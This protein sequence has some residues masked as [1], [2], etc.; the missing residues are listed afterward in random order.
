MTLTFAETCEMDDWEL[1]LLYTNLTEESNNNMSF[2]GKSFNSKLTHC[3]NYRVYSRISR[4]ILHKIC[5][6]YCQ[7]DFYASYTFLSIYFFNQLFKCIQFDIYADRLIYG[8]SFTK[9]YYHKL[10]EKPTLPRN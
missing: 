5:Q 4:E 9:K 10:I 8:T 7:F 1:K 6:K 2:V 3:H